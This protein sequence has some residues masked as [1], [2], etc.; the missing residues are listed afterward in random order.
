MDANGSTSAAVRA[1]ARASHS[2]MR[3]RPSYLKAWIASRTLPT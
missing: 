1:M 2:P 3:H